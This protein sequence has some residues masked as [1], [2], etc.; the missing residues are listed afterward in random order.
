M[1]LID[2]SLSRVAVIHTLCDIVLFGADET[3]SPE[4]RF[5]AIDAGSKRAHHKFERKG[6]VEDDALKPRCYC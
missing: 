2:H 5:F 4:R 6:I 3:L 1:L